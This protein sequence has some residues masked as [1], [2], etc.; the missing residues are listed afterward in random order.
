MALC[1]MYLFSNF[2]KKPDCLVAYLNQIPVILASFL[3]YVT[4]HCLI[5]ELLTQTF[6][7]IRFQSTISQISTEGVIAVASSYKT[8][9]LC[10][11]MSTFQQLL[12]EQATEKACL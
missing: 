10:K 4:N 9:P 5:V 12:W 8:V 1:R 7:S 6:T 2:V 11:I 3:T